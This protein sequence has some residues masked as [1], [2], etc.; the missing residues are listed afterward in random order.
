MHFKKIKLV[1][2]LITSL[3]FSIST[4]ADSKVEIDVKVGAALKQFKREVNGGETFLSKAAGVLVLPEVLKAGFVIGGEYGE[5]ALLIDHKT[6]GYY[7]TASAS[8]GFQLGAQSKAVVLVFLD[9]AALTQFQRSDGWEAGVDG[10]VALL[11]WGTGKDINSVNVKDPIIGFVFSN[12]GL[13][14]NLTIEG[15]KFTKIVR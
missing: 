6:V 13:M 12:K 7:S 15:S 14:Y 2:L 3:C 1:V 11:D 5:G 8:I 10:S 9:K 4:F